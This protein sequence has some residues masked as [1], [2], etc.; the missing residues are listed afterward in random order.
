MYVNGNPILYTDP[1][2]NIC[3]NN[4]ENVDCTKVGPTR[5]GGYDPN[6]S[7]YERNYGP[8]AQVPPSYQY[9]PSSQSDPYLEFIQ[10]PNGGLYCP[11][12]NYDPSFFD[13]WGVAAGGITHD[14]VQGFGEGLY[15]FQGRMPSVTIPFY[16]PQGMGSNVRGA[17]TVAQYEISGRFLRQFGDIVHRASKTVLPVIDTAL[18][19][20]PSL[21]DNYKSN[22]RAT[23]YIADALV[24]G[25]G[26][27]ISNAAGAFVAGGITFL[28]SA[29]SGGTATVPAI[30]VGVTAG[31]VVEAVVADQYERWVD[32]NNIRDA[33]QEFVEQDA[34]DMIQRLF[35]PI[36]NMWDNIQAHPAPNVNTPVGTP[37]PNNP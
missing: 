20:G 19:F 12:Y 33:V 3:Y 15:N 16:I 26:W 24:D 23:E 27:A 36:T 21:V 18:T 11:A 32:N 28:G 7:Y 37:V 25:A 8:N 6:K 22:A 30:G 1:S 5:G 31:V 2:G 10:E 13:G 9:N 4:G 34:K 35:N 29:L 17:G 14:M